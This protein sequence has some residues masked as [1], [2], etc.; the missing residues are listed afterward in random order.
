MDFESLFNNTV[1]EAQRMM[2]G[3]FWFADKF[4]H[5]TDLHGLVGILE[6]QQVWL[7]DHRFLNDTQEISYGRD[8]A[9]R[10]ISAV[11]TLDPDQEFGAFLRSV[12]DLISKP[13]V[14][15]S[16]ICSMSLAIDAL[17]QWKWYA[18]SPDGV[19]I[20]F[21]GE[22][23]LWNRNYSH[24]THI[25]QRKIVYKERDQSSIIEK[26]IDIYRANF[27]AFKDFR[28]PFIRDL[29]GLIED[30]FITFKDEQYESEKEI[31]LTIENLGHIFKTREI[32]HR[33]SKNRVIPYITTGYI[34]NDPE[35]RPN[36]IPVKE[37]IVSPLAKA[38]TVISIKAYLANKGLDSIP[39]TF[40]KVQFRG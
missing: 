34:S 35:F 17:D 31:R 10:K 33:I 21:N 32:K 7:S 8:L 30:Q 5:Y 26:F 13:S 2:D 19:C 20:V 37:I 28:N 14:H 23:E 24:P 22:Q 11:S 29:A 9:I 12:V 6:T 38:E 1:R 18:G 25:R 36:G 4:C 16:Y 15:G 3:P 39:V 40:S 27:N